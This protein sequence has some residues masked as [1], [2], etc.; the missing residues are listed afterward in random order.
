MKASVIYIILKFRVP[1]IKFL[2]SLALK[3]GRLLMRGLGCFLP[4]ISSLLPSPRL[5]FECYEHNIFFLT[6]NRMLI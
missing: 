3:F 4:I 1:L 5:S 6:V 2:P